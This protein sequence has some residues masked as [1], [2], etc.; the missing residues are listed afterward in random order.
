MDGRDLR[1]LSDDLIAMEDDL[2]LGPARNTDAGSDRILESPRV[3]T[4]GATDGISNLEHPSPDASAGIFTG[5][6]ALSLRFFGIDLE[7]LGLTSLAV[8]IAVERALDPSPVLTTVPEMK[9][10]YLTL[11]MCCG[12][13][14]C[15]F[16]RAGDRDWSSSAEE[17]DDEDAMACSLLLEPDPRDRELRVNVDALWEECRNEV[18]RVRSVVEGIGM[19]LRGVVIFAMMFFSTDD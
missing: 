6:G 8:E 11:G 7:R 19:G 4:P 2:L 16:T 13:C 10:G 3:R 1:S 17:D 14:V 12:S 9:P 18:R 5:A 15:T